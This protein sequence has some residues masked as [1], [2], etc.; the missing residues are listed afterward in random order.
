[1]TAK[2][3]M[4][5]TVYIQR[6]FKKPRAL[7]WRKPWQAWQAWQAEVPKTVRWSAILMCGHGRQSPT[8]RIPALLSIA[9]LIARSVFRSDCKTLCLDVNMS[10]KRAAPAQFIKAF[11]ARLNAFAQFSSACERSEIAPRAAMLKSVR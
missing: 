7:A 3:A 8:P 10:L 2:T 1:M 5:F 11:D 4:L 9:R 6:I